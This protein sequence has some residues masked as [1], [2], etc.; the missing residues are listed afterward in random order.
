VALRT[1]NVKDAARDL[2]T[3]PG[4][5]LIATHKELEGRTKTGLAQATA[6]ASEHAAKLP[7]DAILERTPAIR[8]LA[9]SAARVFAW[10]NDKPGVQVIGSNRFQ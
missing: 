2:H 1:P 5:V 10:D 3:Q 4:D 9:A 6:E 8:D 7:G